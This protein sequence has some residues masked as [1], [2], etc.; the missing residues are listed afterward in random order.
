MALF[1]HQLVENGREGDGDT[2]MIGLRGVQPTS[3]TRGTV[4]CPDTIEHLMSFTRLSHH[5]FHPD[6]IL[7]YPVT[8]CQHDP[9]QH[10]IPLTI[11]LNPFVSGRSPSATFP[12]ADTP[13]QCFRR[14]VPLRSVTSTEKA[15]SLMSDGVGRTLV[16]GSRCQFWSTLISITLTQ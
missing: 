4:C 10:K 16:K 7:P 5:E 15:H 9:T 8:S 11:F 3:K 1:A 6:W 13:A 14:T 12:D 2:S